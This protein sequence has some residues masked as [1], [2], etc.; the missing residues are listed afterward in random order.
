MMACCKRISKIEPSELPV[1]LLCSQH[2]CMHVFFE[3][4]VQLAS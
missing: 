2:S 3:P 4:V 1:D